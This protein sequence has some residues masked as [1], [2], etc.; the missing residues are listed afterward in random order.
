MGSGSVKNPK[1]HNNGSE[2]RI[3]RKMFDGQLIYMTAGGFYG[4]GG[5]LNL[6]RIA[7]NGQFP[8]SVWPGLGATKGGGLPTDPHGRGCHPIQY[9]RYCRGCANG[10]DRNLARGVA[11]LLP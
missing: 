11:A 1:Q 8:P 10:P 4:A 2:R 5:G 3:P 9:P 7:P 6:G